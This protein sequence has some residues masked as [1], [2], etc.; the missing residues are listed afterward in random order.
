[1]TGI[2]QKQ[3]KKGIARRATNM[4]MDINDNYEDEFTEFYNE[5]IE[6]VCWNQSHDEPYESMWYGSNSSKINN[7]PAWV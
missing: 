6:R 5:E 7:D 1:M 3:K 4:S 2:K